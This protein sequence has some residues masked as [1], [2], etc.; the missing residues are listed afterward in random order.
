MPEKDC[1]HVGKNLCMQMQREALQESRQVLPSLHLAWSAGDEQ[2]A[3]VGPFLA[4]LARV[5]KVVQSP[6]L[7]CLQESAQ[8]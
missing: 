1:H 4:G 8:E 2:V 3:A 6:Q 7:V 5:N